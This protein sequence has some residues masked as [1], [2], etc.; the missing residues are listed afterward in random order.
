M[1]S[2]FSLCFSKAVLLAIL[3]HWN[4]SYVASHLEDAQGYSHSQ[5]TKKFTQLSD[6]CKTSPVLRKL[7]IISLHLSQLPLPSSPRYR[8]FR[9]LPRSS[10]SFIPP[11]SLPPRVPQP[12]E[13]SSSAS[14]SMASFNTTAQQPQTKSTSIHDLRDY[15]EPTTKN[16]WDAIQKFQ[17]KSDSSVHI[18]QYPTSADNMSRNGDITMGDASAPQELET[19]QNDTVLEA[20]NAAQN[21][22]VLPGSQDQAASFEFTGEDH[23]LGNALR[24]IIMKKC[25]LPLP[26]SSCSLPFIHGWMEIWKAQILGA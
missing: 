16:N 9:K 19:Q 18:Y 7:F 20:L 8:Y 11:A 15:G 12:R 5:T 3:L 14:P 17:P 26:F 21:V 22:R 1:M 10:L 2:T 25:V 24:W 4:P 13:K 23:T 6:H